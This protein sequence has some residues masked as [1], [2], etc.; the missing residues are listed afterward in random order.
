VKIGWEQG[1]TVERYQSLRILAKLRLPGPYRP[2]KAILSGTPCHHTI[3]SDVSQVLFPFSR[4]DDNGKEDQDNPDKL[5]RF[6]CF[7]K[8]D[9]GQD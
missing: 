1:G 3:K 5:R 2:G 7:P 8:D 4:A 9:I 6:N